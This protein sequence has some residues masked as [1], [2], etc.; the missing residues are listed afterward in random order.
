MKLMQ[1]ERIVYRNAGNL[2]ITNMRIRLKK[3]TYNLGKVIDHGIYV[4]H[5][6]RLPWIILIVVGI[7]LTQINRL[8]IVSEY[9]IQN[10]KILD[11]KIAGVV[12]DQE[13]VI[14]STAVCLIIL[15]IIFLIL[16][17]KRYIVRIITSSGHKDIAEHLRNTQAVRLYL[18][19]HEAVLYSPR[20]SW[21]SP[22][23]KQDNLKISRK[24][25]GDRK[26]V[27]LH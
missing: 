9:I 1:K 20:S 19:I 4:K 21:K 8:D 7:V 3:H 13:L 15:G 16:L 5:P 10:I 26:K 12:M 27:A 22:S 23:M 18:A 11:Y 24:F 2:T 25:E 17:R 14:R 6:R